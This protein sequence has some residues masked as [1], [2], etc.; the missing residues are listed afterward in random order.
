[1]RFPPLLAFFATLALTAAERPNIIVILA[2]D[3]G[4]GDVSAYNPKGKIPTPHLDRLAAEG[5]RFTDGHTTSGVCTPSRYSLLTGRYHWRTRLQSGVLGGYSAPLIAK[6]RLTEAEIDLFKMEAMV[7]RE[8]RNDAA[9]EA[10]K[11]QRVL[12]ETGIRLFNLK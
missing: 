6:E 12:D 11:D 1:M 10:K 9:V 7:E 8:A 3:Q 4:L 5:M 2:D